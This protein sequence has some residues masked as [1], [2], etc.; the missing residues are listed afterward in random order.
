MDVVRCRVVM[1][2]SHSLVGDSQLHCGLYECQSKVQRQVM[3]E[4]V[5]RN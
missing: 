3:A 1:K 5:S 2:D 4:R